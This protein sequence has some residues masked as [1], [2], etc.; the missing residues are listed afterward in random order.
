MI[1][2]LAG[3]ATRLRGSLKPYLMLACIKSAL[4]S[5]LASL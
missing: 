4:Q 2:A 3:F 5:S 1:V